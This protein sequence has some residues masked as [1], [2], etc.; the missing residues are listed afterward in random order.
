MKDKKKGPGKA[1]KEPEESKQA[2]KLILNTRP[3]KI[4]ISGY[5]KAFQ[6]MAREQ[7]EAGITSRKATIKAG[8]FILEEGKMVEL[9][10][11]LANPLIR[12]NVIQNLELRK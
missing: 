5:S 3:I 12:K 10:A 6:N 4:R 9:P 7:F 2:L 11:Y 8:D 1:K